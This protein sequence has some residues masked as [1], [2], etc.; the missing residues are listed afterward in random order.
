MSGTEMR[1]GKKKCF[2]TYLYQS[3]S[4]TSEQFEDFCTDLNL[5]LSNV[6]DFNPAC[7][8]ITGDFNAKSPQ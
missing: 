8:V 6:N 3:P 2:F 1:I 4:Q 7:S 5:F